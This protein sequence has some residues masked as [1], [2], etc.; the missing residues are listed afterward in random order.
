MGALEKVEHET[1]GAF[2]PV[3]AVSE[4]LEPKKTFVPGLEPDESGEDLSKH[5]NEPELDQGGQS[6]AHQELPAAVQNCTT[7]S[8]VP[9][10]PSRRVAREA[11]ATLPRSRLRCARWTSTICH[12][13][14][15]GVP[16][17]AKLAARAEKRNGRATRAPSMRDSL[18][19]Q[20]QDGARHQNHPQ[21][22][23][24]KGRANKKYK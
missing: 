23:N 24:H 6:G 13:S 21:T 11:D 1:E 9:L 2:G 22:E 10:N 12:R 17:M 16:R 19:S 14:R 15:P 8:R 4:E 3:G 18:P 7:R 5:E 20:G